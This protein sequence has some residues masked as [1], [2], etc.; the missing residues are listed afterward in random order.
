MTTAVF[1]TSAT[2]VPPAWL[3]RG[4]ENPD[5]PLAPAELA[6]ELERMRATPVVPQRPVLVLSGWRAWRFMAEGVARRL[7][8]LVGG[9]EEMYHAVAYPLMTDL[10]AI[11][12]RVVRETERRWPCADPHR[13]TEVDVV[14]MS[15]GGLV[16]RVAAQLPLDAGQK[17]LRVARLFTL[18]TPHRGARLAGRVAIDAAARD[19][20]PGCPFIDRLNASLPTARYELVPYARLH[21]WWVGATNAAPPGRDPIW[22][23]GTWLMSHVTIGADPRIAADIARRLRAELPLAAGPSRPPHD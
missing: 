5:F 21:D 2:A 8:A 17:R 23:A 1:P 3:S 20:R 13:T 10:G 18:A 19:M 6:L 22:F 11:A 15:M 12:R 7:R 16:A 14:A 4:P 9:P